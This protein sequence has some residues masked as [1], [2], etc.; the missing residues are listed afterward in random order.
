MDIP[1]NHYRP[2][3]EVMIGQEAADATMRDRRGKVAR[4]IC[5]PQFGYVYS[6]HLDDGRK[7]RVLEPTLRK[8]YQ[9]G[10]WESCSWQPRLLSQ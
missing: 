4:I 8:I 7:G 9:Q 2:G 1:A 3:E 5:H 6:I 10:S